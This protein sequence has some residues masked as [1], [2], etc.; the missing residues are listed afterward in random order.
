MFGR[1]QCG[2]VGQVWKF[3]VSGRILHVFGYLAE[4]WPTN[5]LCVDQVC[6]LVVK[7]W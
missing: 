5:L 7:K 1:G 4:L 2:I 3:C 6:V